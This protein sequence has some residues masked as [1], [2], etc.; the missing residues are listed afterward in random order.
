MDNNRQL[1]ELNSDKLLSEETNKSF[2]KIA[3]DIK[4]LKEMFNDQKILTT[5]QDDNYEIIENKVGKIDDEIKEIVVDL[6]NEKSYIHPTIIV[7]SILS[8]II[9]LGLAGLLI[10]L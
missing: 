2:E 4:E 3:E 6:P 10:I 7:I 5:N 9:T 1:I 8:G